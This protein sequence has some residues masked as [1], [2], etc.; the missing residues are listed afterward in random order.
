MKRTPTTEVPELVVDV[1]ADLRHRTHR[2]RR[3]RQA[4][5]LERTVRILIQG[6]RADRNP[7]GHAR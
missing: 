5:V 4:E 3:L 7:C 2:K 6:K 1:Q